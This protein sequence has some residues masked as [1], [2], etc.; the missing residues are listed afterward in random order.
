MQMSLPSNAARGLRT[1]DVITFAGATYEVAKIT[2]LG[3]VAALEL[4]RV[5]E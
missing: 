1:G 5:L 4:I 2:Y 3:D